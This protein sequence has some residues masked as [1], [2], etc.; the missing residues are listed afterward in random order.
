MLALRPNCENCGIEL[1][2]HSTDAMICSYECTF[3]KN[4]V[5]QILNNVC[6]NCG[7]GFCSRPVRPSNN[8]KNNNC[9]KNDPASEKIVLKPVSKEQHDTFSSHIKNIAPEKR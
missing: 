9:L 1:L 7:G 6:P 5:D 8:W 4:C 3:C 2:P